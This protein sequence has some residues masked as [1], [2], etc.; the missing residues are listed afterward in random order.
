MD[1]KCPICILRNNYV[2]ISEHGEDALQYVFTKLQEVT[3]MLVKG[4]PYLLTSPLCAYIN[5]HFYDNS[6]AK[7]VFRLPMKTTNKHC[8]DHVKFHVESIINKTVGQFMMVTDKIGPLLEDDVLFDET[9][10]GDGDMEV[11][12]N[13]NTDKKLK[14]LYNYQT[15]SLLTIKEL[16]KKII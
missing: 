16:I 15:C 10:N 7:I 2:K 1:K 5:S 9:Q 12:C 14:K 13:E 6:N 4:D 3:H 8:T 11:V